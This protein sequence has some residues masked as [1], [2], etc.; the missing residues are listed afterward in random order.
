MEASNQ[1]T[2]AVDDDQQVT[3]APRLERQC[4]RK[5]VNGTNIEEDLE[6]Y[7][8]SLKRCLMNCY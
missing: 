2:F 6:E 4:K 8:V 1:V 5:R 3:T 7:E